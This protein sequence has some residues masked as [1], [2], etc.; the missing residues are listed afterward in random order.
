MS[1]VIANLFSAVATPAVSVPTTVE[2]QIKVYVAVLKK[3]NAQGMLRSLVKDET[4]SAETIDQAEALLDYVNKLDESQKVAVRDQLKSMVDAAEAEIMAKLIGNAQ[5]KPDA[6]NLTDL[7]TEPEK[8]QTDE[9]PASVQAASVQVIQADG[10]AGLGSLIAA[11]VSGTATPAAAN[12]Q[13]VVDAIS[14]DIK[15]FDFSA[16]K[17]VFKIQ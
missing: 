10:L 16:L 6:K 7:M 5:A 2:A 13:S 8:A 4:V 11:L 15:D 1:N 9:Q 14:K 12:V 17:S 3:F